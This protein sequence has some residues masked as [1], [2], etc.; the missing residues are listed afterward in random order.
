M[1]DE[2]Q[3]SLIAFNCVVVQSKYGR[4]ASAICGHT[5]GLQLIS[6]YKSA[7]G[8]GQVQMVDGLPLQVL[9]VVQ[10]LEARQGHCPALQQQLDIMAAV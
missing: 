5:Q 4:G 9:A 6:A 1:V 7:V 2:R 3:R 10:Q 8:W